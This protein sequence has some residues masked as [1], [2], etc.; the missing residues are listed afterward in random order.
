LGRTNSPY[1]YI[2]NIDENDRGKVLTLME[3]LNFQGIEL[4]VVKSLLN[5]EGETYP[6]NSFI[7]FLSQP[8]RQNI[9]ALLEKQS[10]PPR[11]LYP[12]GPPEAPYDIASWNL[13]EQMDIKAK[14]LNQPFP[15][16]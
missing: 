15:A 7:V 10:Y 1:G 16:F 6:P 12:G 11:F 13:L 2:F 8:Q 14:E 3:I 9:L 5:V 4:H